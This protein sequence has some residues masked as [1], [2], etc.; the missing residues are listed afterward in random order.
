MPTQI[1]TTAAM[2]ANIPPGPSSSAVD[3]RS[4]HTRSQTT[5][6][7]TKIPDQQI[8]EV[9]EEH[10]LLFMPPFFPAP[11]TLAE[12]D[13]LGPVLASLPVSVEL[14]S[15]TMKIGRAHV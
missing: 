8:A 6:P 9:V 14:G 5:E 4:L 15:L 7:A 13:V 3:H 11:L 2:T 12:K 10:A 1:P